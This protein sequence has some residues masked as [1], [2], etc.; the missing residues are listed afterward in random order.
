MAIITEEVGDIFSAPSKSILIRTFPPLPP[1]KTRPAPL[2]TS[3]RRLQRPR[4]LGLRGSRRFQTEPPLRLSPIS[5]TLPLT[6]HGL[7]ALRQTAPSRSSRH[8]PTHS[9]AHCN[10][11][12]A[13]IQETSLHSLPIHLSRLRK[14][15]LAR[16]GNS[17]KHKKR[18]RK[19]SE[20]SC[21]DEKIGR[22]GG[23]V[24]CGEDQQREIRCRV[25]EDEGGV[26]GWR[27]GY[28]GFKA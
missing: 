13:S 15:G 16:G 26:G 10:R 24:L 27:A 23:Q 3:Q 2:T 21:G 6:A 7:Q 5:R 8:D 20:T 9:S 28:H 22:R 14:K 4:R 1:P 17:R 11:A 19:P 25:A 18:A 12:A